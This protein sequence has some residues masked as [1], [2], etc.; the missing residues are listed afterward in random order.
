[1]WGLVGIVG[2]GIFIWIVSPRGEVS[3]LHLGAVAAVG[4][5]WATMTIV[6]LIGRWRYRR[7]A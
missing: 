3:G 1:M 7:R 4:V 6:V 2:F 5:P